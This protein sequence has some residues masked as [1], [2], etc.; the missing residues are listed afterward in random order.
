MI[1]SHS[2]IF[3]SEFDKDRDEVVAGAKEAG[4]TK[5]LMPN[6]D[7]ETIPP[8]LNTEATYPDFCCAMMGLHPTSV[9][10]AYGEQLLTVENWLGKRDFVAIGEIGID[11]YW[12]TSR[13]KEQREVFATQ[14]RWAADFGKPV[15]IHVRN[16]FE[17]VFE[18]LDKVYDSRL[19]GVFHS[20]SGSEAQARRALEYDGFMLGINGIIT[21]KNSGL[22]KVIEAVGPDRL[23]LETDA[24]YLTP[25]PYRGKRNQP[26]FLKY[27]LEKLANVF[28]MTPE[29][30]DEL[31]TQ[32][33][34]QLFGLDL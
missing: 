29:K 33:A 24:P 15:V 14:L 10:E 23:M 12:D 30:L 13:E 26:A 28:N 11:L 21:F 34:A 25:V 18:E 8:L 31:T 27:T 7:E 2:H 6:I 9:K 16:A 4:V 22:D 32:N 17:A 20:F 19:K 1:D 5:I 3:L